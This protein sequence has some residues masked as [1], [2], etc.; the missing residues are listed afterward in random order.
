M[1]S[2]PAP[3]VQTLLGA[4][5][6][7]LDVQILLADAPH[8]PLSPGLPAHWQRPVAQLWQ[9][10]GPEQ[11][12]QEDALLQLCR[13]AFSAAEGKHSN[14]LFRMIISAKKEWIL[15]SNRYCPGGWGD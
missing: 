14:A 13:P 5:R 8:N 7:K 10:A 11:Q 6:S 1:S 15:H 2:Q 9:R 4:D 12:Q 3:D